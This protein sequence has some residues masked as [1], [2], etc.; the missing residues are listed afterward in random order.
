MRRAY[1]NAN[2]ANPRGCP[3]GDDL[4]AFDDAR[5]DLVFDPGIQVFGVLAHDY[6][7]DVF[8]PGGHARE[9]PHWPEVGIKVQR[10]AQTDVHAREAFGDGRRGG[11]L[12]RDLVSA[13]RLNE[14]RWQ[15]LAHLFERRHARDVPFPFDC[16]SRRLE[17]AENGFGD[18]R[19]DAVAGD[20]SNGVGHTCAG[21]KSCAAEVRCMQD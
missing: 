3:R 8:E 16:H 21:P 14:V 4:Q 19:A 2:R 15:C 6:E 11:S 9:L 20:Q 1:A 7:I 10:L 13:N 12:Q 5:H 18:F 17:N